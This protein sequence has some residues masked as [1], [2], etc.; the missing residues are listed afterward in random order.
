MNK[1]SVHVKSEH[2]CCSVNKDT[3]VNQIYHIVICW[4]NK[5][6]V[7]FFICFH[8]MAKVD[9]WLIMKAWASYYIFLSG[10]ISKNL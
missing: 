2:L 10:K 8:M 9:L 3:I 1:D 4:R 6:L 7:Q 5:K